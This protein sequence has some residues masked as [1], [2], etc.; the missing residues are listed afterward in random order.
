VFLLIPPTHTTDILLKFRIHSPVIN[1]FLN[2]FCVCLISNVCKFK[3]EFF[4]FLDGVPMGSPLSSLLVE[5]FMDKLEN[6]VF[7][8]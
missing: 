8:S 4:S 6:E 1:E 7:D 3:N 2:L 5:I